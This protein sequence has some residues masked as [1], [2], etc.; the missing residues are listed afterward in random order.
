MKQGLQ[1][2]QW[3]K[4]LWPINRSLTGQGV[5]D[6]LAYLKNLLPPLQTHSIAS[7]TSV[8]DWTVPEEWHCDE[9]YIIAPD[10]QRICDYSQNNLH[11]VGYSTAIDISISLNELKP[12][13]YSMPDQ[14]DYIPYVTSYFNKIWGFC[15][16]HNDLNRLRDGIYKVV[17]KSNHFDGE[18]NYAD[19]I[20]R[21]KTDN[22]ILLSTYA[23]HPSMANNELSGPVLVAALG[24]WLL[25]NQSQLKHS[26]RLV[27]TP[28]TVG[29]IT[30]LSK[31]HEIL[32]QHVIGGFQVTTVGDDR[33]FSYIESPYADTLSDVI[34][35]EVL[36]ENGRGFKTY[37]FLH[38][39][40]DERQYCA[41]HIRLP[42]ASICRTKYAEY[43]EY[44]TSA[45]NLI[46]VVTPK[47]LQGAYDVYLKCIKRFEQ[48]ER[49]PE[50]RQRQQLP[51]SPVVTC[52]CEPQLGKR[53][54]YNLISYKGSQQDTRQLINVITYCDGTNTAAN[55]AEIIGVSEDE[56]LETIQLLKQHALIH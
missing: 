25:E 38:R 1:M 22:E 19:A 54:L 29:A 39:G 37:S 13:L 2:H 47:G 31:H 11:L 3:A 5:R 34:A 9:A 56:C 27:I 23:C 45:D 42:I 50:V 15:L 55:I 49:I 35:R 52:L 7:G 6:S 32:K 4:D 12:Y 8:F 24:Q 18:L 14:P 30:Y 48:L 41:P 36:H 44:H 21:G 28:E 17:I 40:S 16:S 46:D 10:G 20:I 26:Y 33:G 51:E 43:P 53:G